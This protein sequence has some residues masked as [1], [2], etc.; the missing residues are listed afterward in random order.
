MV[1]KLRCEICSPQQISSSSLLCREMG[2]ALGSFGLGHQDAG[3]QAVSARPNY[4]PFVSRNPQNTSVNFRGKGQSGPVRPQLG[5]ENLLHKTI[6]SS[7][8][9]CRS[10]EEVRPLF[11]LA[12]AHS[13]L[14]MKNARQKQQE[15]QGRVKK[16]RD[17][18]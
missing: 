8:L 17:H 5:C 10:R 12:H 18:T 13:G 4:P 14:K 9:I 6:S 7:S 2:L 11:F 16:T 1:L 3:R 15:R